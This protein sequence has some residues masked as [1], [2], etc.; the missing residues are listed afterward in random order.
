[1]STQPT[2]SFIAVIDKP[3]LAA[4]TSATR[5]GLHAQF[6]RHA[7]VHVV[8][9]LGTLVCT[10]ALAFVLP[11]FLSVEDYGYYRLFLLYGGFAGVLHLGFLDGLLLRWAARPMPRLRNELSSSLLFLALEQTAVLAPVILAVAL[12]LPG[13]YLWITLA[14]SA[15]AVLWNWAT[16]GQC[17]LQGLKLF[18]HLSFFIILGPFLIL[19]T[20]VALHVNHRLDLR[21]LILTCLAANLAAAACLWLFVRRRVP[22]NRRAMRNVLG[23]GFTYIG[24]GWSLVCAN[25]LATVALTL[26]KLVL[27]RVSPIREFAIYSFAA[28]ALALTYNMILS[29]AR[30][31]FPYLSDGIPVAVRIRAYFTGERI[32]LLTWAAGLATY[33]PIAWLIARWLPRYV[34]SLP[35]IRILMLATG[36]TASIHV[37][38]SSYFRVVRKQGRFLIGAVSGVA[39]AALFLGIGARTGQLSHFAWAMVGSA[40]TWWLANEFLLRDVLNHNSRRIVGTLALTTVCAVAYLF[41]TSLSNLTV[42][43]FVY[44]AWTALLFAFLGKPVLCHL[45]LPWLR[46]IYPVSPDNV[47]IH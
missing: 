34:E 36:F 5:T 38:H 39:S 20:A 26:D 33:F 45:R 30:V 7:I 13:I 22:N 14:V 15:Y 31:L 6:A 21:S 2:D 1:M 41:C 19:V 32:L 35:I 9:N 18:T 43:F 10:G 11:R 37:L 23:K 42:G 27:S 28:N 12:L 4:S 16:L 24:L 3:V 44:L 25:L 8:A 46:L 29:L 40:L 17:A 47:S